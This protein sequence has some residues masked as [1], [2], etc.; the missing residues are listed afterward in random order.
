MNQLRAIIAF[1]CRVLA[2]S[3]NKPNN[4][5]GFLYVQVAVLDIG[6]NAIMVT[7]FL[8]LYRTGCFQMRQYLIRVISFYTMQ[9]ADC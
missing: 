5:D 9:Q 6:A 8:F 1:S 2:R 4:R 3:A 7:T